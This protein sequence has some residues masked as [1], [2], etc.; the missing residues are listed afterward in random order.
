MKILWTGPVTAEFWENGYKIFTKSLQQCC[1]PPDIIVGRLQLVIV[2]SASV[3][4]T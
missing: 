2:N 1:V 4:T 3:N